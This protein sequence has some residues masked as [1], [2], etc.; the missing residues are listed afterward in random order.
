[1]PSTQAPVPSKDALQRLL[2]GLQTLIREHLAL[3]RAEIRD[4]VRSMGRDLVVAAAGVPALIA[5]YLLVMVASGYLL[6][7]WLPLWASFGIVALVNLAA[8]AALTLAGT[9][10][11]MQKRPGLP[12]TGEELQRDKVWLAALNENTRP[13]TNGRT[14]LA[15]EARQEG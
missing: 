3:A 8:G 12:R 10:K 14:A 7:L 9:R 2:D 4:D 11:V 15:R 6:S 13:E 1:M 5:G